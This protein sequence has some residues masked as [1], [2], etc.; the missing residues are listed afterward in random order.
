MPK[1]IYHEEHEGH[2]G[3]NSIQAT[4]FVTGGVQRCAPGLRLSR[5]LA[6]R[7]QADHLGGCSK[8]DRLLHPPSA[9]RVLRGETVLYLC[10]SFVATPFLFSYPLKTLRDHRG[11]EETRG[12][13]YLNP[14][15]VIVP[16]SHPL[17]EDQ[18]TDYNGSSSFRVGN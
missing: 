13:G 1:G 6:G 17:W 3:W 15:R 8:Q 10:E 4:A 9:L 7:R 18:I 12:Y 2:E 16:C 14:L 5:G 11:G